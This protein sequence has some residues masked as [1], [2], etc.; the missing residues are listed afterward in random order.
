LI[1]DLLQ[2]LIQ[3]FTLRQEVVQ[4]HLPQHAAQRGLREL[5]RGEVVVLDFDD[6]PVGIHHTEV[7]DR[8][9]LDRHVVSRNHILGRHVQHHRAQADADHAINRP[10]HQADAGPFGR[11]NSFRSR[12]MSARSYS[13]S[14]LIELIR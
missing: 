6:G 4:L 2:L 9:H 10:E 14:I 5:R 12:K 3:P 1:E 13:A 11:D 8:V 7:D